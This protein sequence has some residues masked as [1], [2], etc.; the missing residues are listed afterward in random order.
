MSDGKAIDCDLT[1]SVVDELTGSDNLYEILENSTPNPAYG[2][3][4]LDKTAAKTGYPEGP[5][6]NEQRGSVSSYNV[7]TNKGSTKANAFP[8]KNG[9]ISPIYLIALVIAVVFLIVA[10]IAIIMGF[11][12]ISKLHAEVAVLQSALPRQ[13]TA[14]QVL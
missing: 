9:V 13:A 8:L 10:G 2:C 14:I 4:T 12:E 3:T 11:V 6:P 7:E 5:H 1:Y